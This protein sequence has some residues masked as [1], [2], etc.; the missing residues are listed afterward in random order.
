MTGINILSANHQMGRGYSQPHVPQYKQSHGS[1]TDNRVAGSVIVEKNTARE[2]NRFQADLRYGKAAVYDSPSLSQETRMLIR[3]LRRTAG[4]ETDQGDPSSENGIKL[5]TDPSAAGEGTT[6]IKKPVNYNYKEVATKIQQAKTSVSAGRAV[7]SAGRKV[8]EIKRKISVHEGDA[9]EL[10]LALTHAKRME[11]VAR[12]KKHHLELEEMAAHIRKSDENSKNR[13]ETASD[14]K[15]A[16]ISA[17]EEEVSVREDAVF[18]ERKELLDEAVAE[19]G[20]QMADEMNEI[21]AE[22]GEEELKALEETMEIFEN[23]EILDPHMSRED[24]EELKRKHRAS[25]NKAMV[26]ADMDYLKDMISYQ[27]A[28]QTAL[29]S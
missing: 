10:Q 16:L 14:I 24:L 25:E 6:E 29:L 1:G 17:A 7:L 13:E 21:I 3:E 15:N 9:K 8:L 26:K 2:N 4:Q 11:M 23:M 12:K 28:G 19:N 22:F 27:S 18:D 5:L 20:D